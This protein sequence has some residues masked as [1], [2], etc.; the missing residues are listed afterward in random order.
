VSLPSGSSGAEMTSAFSTAT[1]PTAAHGLLTSKAARA[2]ASTLEPRPSLDSLA[3]VDSPPAAGLECFEDSEWMEGLA[4]PRLGAALLARAARCG[5]VAA[6]ARL[7]QGGSVAP[8]ACEVQ[9]AAVGDLHHASVS[10]SLAGP[11]RAA[12]PG[13]RVCD[14]AAVHSCA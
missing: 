8:W 3:S 1:P 12:N 11:P 13:A 10:S 2:R 9:L 5:V 6:L 14:T 7:C 4:P